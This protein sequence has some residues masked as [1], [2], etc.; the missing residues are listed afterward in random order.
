MSAL[1]VLVKPFHKHRLQQHTSAEDKEQPLLP[2][3]RPVVE[4]EQKTTEH[5]LLKCVAVECKRATNSRTCAIDRVVYASWWSARSFLTSRKARL[6]ALVD[7]KGSYSFLILIL[8]QIDVPLVSPSTAFFHPS[9]FGAK[10]SQ[11][12]KR[13]EIL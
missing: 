8:H 12:G 10:A 3:P 4:E 5:L 13:K 11:G 1:G 9:S 7:L 2:L 6:N